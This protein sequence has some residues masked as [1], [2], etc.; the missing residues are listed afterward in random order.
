MW[1]A[2][3]RLLA[4]TQKSGSSERQRQLANQLASAGTDQ[5]KLEQFL[6]ACGLDCPSDLRTQAQASID[7]IKRQTDLT[8]QEDAAY[9]AARGDLD[10]LRAYLSSCTKCTFSEAAQWEIARLLGG[11]TI[12]D[13]VWREQQANIPSKPKDTNPA[14]EVLNKKEVAPHVSSRSKC[15]MFNGRRVCD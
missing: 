1:T 14:K 8:S 10:K 11:V 9:L 13:R 7:T 6:S 4:I 5:S 2:N 15:L 12:G 3:N